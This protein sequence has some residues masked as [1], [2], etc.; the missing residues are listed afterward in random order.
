MPIGVRRRY[1]TAFD[2][3]GVLKVTASTSHSSVQS[4]TAK[5]YTYGTTSL[6]ASRNIGVPSVDYNGQIV[7]DL[8]GLLSSLS[9]GVYSV[10]VLAT[11]SSG[12]Q[13]STGTPVAV[14]LT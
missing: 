2:G 13:E 8:S 11:F 9:T 12:T 3:P 10:S 14:P 7:H 6:V 1:V 4:Y 5:I